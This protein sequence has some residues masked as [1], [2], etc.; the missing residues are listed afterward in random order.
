MVRPTA[1]P[2]PKAPASQDHVALAAGRT[3]SVPPAL[4]ATDGLPVVTAAVSLDDKGRIVGA[5]G[6]PY[7]GVELFYDEKQDR[8]LDSTHKAFDANQIGSQPHSSEAA[9]ATDAKHGHPLTGVMLDENNRLVTPDGQ[10]F[11]GWELTYDAANDRVLDAQGQTVDP[12][13]LPGWVSSKERTKD[14]A[15]IVR[16][17]RVGAAVASGLA[18][19]GVDGL[20]YRRSLAGMQGRVGSLQASTQAFAK[21]QSLSGRLAETPVVGALARTMNSRQT[22]KITKLNRAMTLAQATP[23]QEARF[24]AQEKL[25]GLQSASRAFKSGESLAGRLKDA[26]V[27]GS[28]VRATESRRQTTI[29]Q[30]RSDLRTDAVTPG[31]GTRVRNAVR[32]RV[33]PTLMLA[34]DGYAI[35]NNAQN[36]SAP[37]NVRKW[38]DALRIAGNGLSVAGDLMAFKRG[39]ITHAIV[40][41]V[42]GVAVTMAGHMANDQD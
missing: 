8:V 36:W 42:A 24:R 40:T 37:G 39:D 6:R 27:V 29:R 19:A 41:H 1:A 26:P 23:M 35:Y 21:G 10:P 28:A 31:V 20:W 34:V 38:D 7:G 16:Q 4:T 13:K 11:M 14:D 3:G 33:L 32:G 25:Q 30:L 17:I 12:K 5:D 18:W 15:T 22:A 2:A 9:H